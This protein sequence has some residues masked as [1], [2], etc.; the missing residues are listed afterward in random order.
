[1]KD[2]LTVLMCCF[3]L[4]AFATAVEADGKNKRKRWG[5]GRH[6]VE[7]N[8][9]RDRLDVVEQRL[10]EAE[11]RINDLESAEPPQLAQCPCFSPAIL[12]RSDW[13]A[14]TGVGGVA[15]DEDGN[16]L[17]DVSTRLEGGGGNRASV[18]R[19]DTVSPGGEIIASDLSCAID[20]MDSMIAEENL[21][22]AEFNACEG[23]MSDL[24]NRREL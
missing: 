23:N 1:M 21:S 20:D 8:V 24:A 13:V 18:T 3:C 5:G 9:L 17:Q 16:E 12:S 15:I 22:E 10:S 19:V 14:L 11:M 4:A 6:I 7:L 2:K